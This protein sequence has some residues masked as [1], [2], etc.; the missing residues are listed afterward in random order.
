MIGLQRTQ[1]SSGIE[2]RLLY[3]IYV[4]A[5]LYAFH[6]SLTLYVES[7]FLERA[8]ASIRESRA[9]QLV[10]LAYATASV[11][12]FFVLMNISRILGA[13]GN[14]RLAFFLI[15]AEAAS[16]IGLAYFEDPLVI[17]FLFLMHYVFAWTVI[18][19]LDIFLESFSNDEETGTIRGTYNTIV[20]AAV[21][22]G[23]FI[24]GLILTDGEYWKLFIAAAVLVAPTILFLSAAFSRFKDPHYEQVPFRQALGSILA[25][26]N[27][28]RIM[29]SNFLLRLFF[30]WMIVYVPIYLHTSLGIE[31][32]VIVGMIIPIALLPFTLFEFM[33]GKIADETL[34]EQELLTAGFVI[35]AFF[36]IM[37]SFITSSSLIVWAI[38][39]FL[40][41][42]GA[43][44]IEIMSDT[45]FFKK[46]D[47]SDA[48]LI[49][50]MR[51]LRNVA[52]FLG[53]L[54]ATVALFFVDLR[55]IFVLLGI[56]LLTGLI[57]SLNLEDT[58]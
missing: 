28:V 52:Y 30:S 48:Y 45:Y 17:I 44:F 6:L 50:Y 9:D 33:L 11:I 14:F 31:M 15:A 49:G 2:H 54:L 47:A 42:T 20:N 35:A 8:I 29:Y 13:V 56:V 19:N 10:G 32:S 23:P 55:Y 12:S 25:R 34:G 5:F 27:I 3:V 43:A 37:I 22:L 58:R 4:A 21:L 53:P 51:N 16:L 7:S 36:T 1:T 40:S 41:R 26:P 24:A 46:I 57:S 39:L 18:F 38:I